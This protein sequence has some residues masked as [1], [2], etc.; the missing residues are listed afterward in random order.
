MGGRRVKKVTGEKVP[1]K[2]KPAKKKPEKKAVPKKPA[3]PVKKRVKK[4]VRGKHY[5]E[6]KKK[7]ETGKPYPLLEAVKLVKESSFASFDASVEAHINLNL[8]AEQQV[9][10]A[11]TL[12]HGTGKEVK[13]LVFAKGKEGE[14]ALSAGAD[15]VGDEETI[16]KIG[17]SGKVPFDAVVATPEFMPKLAKIARILGP[18]GLMPSPKSGTVA[19]NPA[20]VVAQLKKG[21]VEL[22][23]EKQPII[24]TVIGKVS[25]PEKNLVENLKAIVEELN[26]V[27]PGGIKGEYIKSVYLK[28]TMGP[29]IK[30]NLRSLA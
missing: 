18:Q 17:E 22:R 6:A 13:V 14:A 27:K 11:I 28:S 1:K 30:V 12:P 8:G 23:T 16:E 7:I 26:R 15:E 4:K 10:T 5:Q 21:R 3:K 24:H 2:K 9:R 29:S 20:E 19:D 25:F